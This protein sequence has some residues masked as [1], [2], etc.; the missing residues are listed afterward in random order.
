MPLFNFGDILVINF[1]FAEGVGS[2]RRPVM[3]L[4]DTEDDDL[5][6]C[7]ITSKNYSSDF[8][9]EIKEWQFAN[10]LS[11]STI[12]IHKIQTVNNKLIFGKIGQLTRS[13]KKA[14]RHKLIELLMKI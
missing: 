8:D 2:K 10:L 12:R 3:I 1:P 14:I 7:K 13:D 4:K 11:P 5:L 6:V 9:S